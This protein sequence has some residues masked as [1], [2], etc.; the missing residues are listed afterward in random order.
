MVTPPKTDMEPK[1]D[2]LEDDSRSSSKGVIFHCHVSFRGGGGCIMFFQGENQLTLN[3]LY[4]RKKTYPKN[5][6]ISRLVGTGDPIPNRTLLKQE[7]RKTPSFLGRVQS[8]ILRV[9]IG[10]MYGIYLPTFTIFCH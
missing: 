3:L 4:P 9:P 1:N 7:S 10:S 8:L 2:D 6:G 5:H